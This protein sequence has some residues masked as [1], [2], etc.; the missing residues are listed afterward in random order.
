MIVAPLGLACGERCIKWSADSVNGFD[1]QIA[2]VSYHIAQD[3]S[4]VLVR[5]DTNALD[6]LQRDLL[7]IWMRARQL[8]MRGDLR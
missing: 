6:D 5:L 7:S 8:C 4:D 3:P 2:Y 1:G